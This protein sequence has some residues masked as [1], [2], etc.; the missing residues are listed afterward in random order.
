M[1]PAALCE[2]GPERLGRGQAV[3]LC[4]HIGHAASNY[5]AAGACVRG[6]AQ[7]PGGLW[8]AVV[9]T[10]R[11]QE[12]LSFAAGHV[13]WQEGAVGGGGSGWAFRRSCWRF[14]GKGPISAQWT[15]W[16]WLCGVAG[17]QGLGVVAA[18][19]RCWGVA[20][21][22]TSHV[23]WLCPQVQSVFGCTG[24]VGKQLFKTAK[25]VLHSRQG[26]Q[27]NSHVKT[28]KVGG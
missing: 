20:W 3:Q 22:G 17:D 27:S 28:P 18:G 9:C 10:H 6:P 1:P 14:G 19:G 26:E 4:A 24:W 16:Q 5:Q 15:L 13:C 23:D 21:P 12:G 25:R 7:H 8:W 11:R 2:S